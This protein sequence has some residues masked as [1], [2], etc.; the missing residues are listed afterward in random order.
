[1]E[2]R[3][4]KILKG[5]ESMVDA[6]RSPCLAPS[7]SSESHRD[8]RHSGGLWSCDCAYYTSGHARCKHVYAVRAMLLMR[9]EASREI[10]NARVEVPEIR[11]AK[12]RVANFRESTTHGARRG[13]VAV[14]RRDDPGAGAGS[15]G[16]RSSMENSS[17]TE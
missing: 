14:Y 11:R 10:K 17:P 15:S 3:G 7:A 9:G 12:R 8:V 1:M 4:P 5:K 16:G 2:A 6:G 13:T